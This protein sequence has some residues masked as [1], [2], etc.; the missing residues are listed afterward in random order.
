[1]VQLLWRT[2]WRCLKKLK[3]KLPYDPETPLLGIQLE[4][5]KIQK[6]TYTL[7]FT[8]VQFTIAKAWKQPN[9]PL[10]DE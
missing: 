3:I 6:A 4:K 8:A 1:M 9:H 7:V 2:K 5:T 10:T